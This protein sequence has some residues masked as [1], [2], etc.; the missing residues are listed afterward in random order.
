MKL[1]WAMRTF[2]WK[3]RAASFFFSQNRPKNVAQ[4]TLKLQLCS[5]R[6]NIYWLSGFVWW[7]DW[8]H[9]GIVTVGGST[10]APKF[11][12]T[13]ITGPVKNWIVKAEENGCLS[14]QVQTSWCWSFTKMLTILFSITL[15]FF[16]RNETEV[17]CGRGSAGPRKPA[18]RR[19]RS[20]GLAFSLQPLWIWRQLP[21]Q[22]PVQLESRT[23]RTHGRGGG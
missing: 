15:F 13:I 12:F 3:K 16:P 4:Q 5:Q 10:V 8:C 14:N 17:W 7:I 6:T 9:F 1:S 11:K 18:R 20:A 23:W 2:M 21:L 19:R 22:V